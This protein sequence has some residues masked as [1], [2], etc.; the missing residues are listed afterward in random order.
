MCDCSIILV[1]RILPLPLTRL[2]EFTTTR[3]RHTPTV[4]TKTCMRGC[5]PCALV[6]SLPHWCFTYR[7]VQCI[8]LCSVKHANTYLSPASCDNFFGVRTASH[9]ARS[10]LQYPVKKVLPNTRSTRDHRVYTIAI[11]CYHCITVWAK[12]VQPNI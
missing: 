4:D 3:R 9:Q 5:L 2:H 6:T 1:S 10:H 11:A 7:G 8:V 12:P